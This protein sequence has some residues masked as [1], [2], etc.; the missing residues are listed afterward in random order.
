M[1][2]R[3]LLFFL[4]RLFK[5]EDDAVVFV[6]TSAALPEPPLP[7]NK[8]TK[9]HRKVNI[10]DNFVGAYRPRQKNKKLYLNNHPDYISRKNTNIPSCKSSKHKDGWNT[11]GFI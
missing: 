8:K 4:L 2:L 5:I 3:P 6:N 7:P 11:N 1:H 9:K 10:I